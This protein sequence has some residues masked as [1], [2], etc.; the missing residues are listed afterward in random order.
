MSLLCIIM[1]VPYLRPLLTLL[2]FFDVL[3]FKRVGILLE[4]NTL[5][6][7]EEDEPPEVPVLK[8]V[9][10]EVLT[11]CFDTDDQINW[12]K[13]CFNEA[14]PDD[15]VYHC[16]VAEDQRTVVEFYYP[17]YPCDKGK[18]FKDNLCPCDRCITS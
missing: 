13:L 2:T 6:S 18:V 10:C 15:K 14:Y 5:K 16:G 12:R 7:E 8:P 1:K 4:A 17:P 3:I 9:Y 11:K